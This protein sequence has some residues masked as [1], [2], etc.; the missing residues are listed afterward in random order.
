MTTL[1]QTAR[2]LTIVMLICFFGGCR[3]D[4][5]CY[6]HPHKMPVRVN[7]DWK[8]FFPFERPTGMTVML[9]SDDE[10]GTVYT[11]LTNTT[12]HAYLHI[13]AGTYHTLVFN[14]S[15]TEFGSFSFRDMDIHSAAVV[16]S[17]VGSRWYTRGESSTVAMDAEWMAVG[18]EYDCVLEQQEI[19]EHGTI[20]VNKNNTK[21]V[22]EDEIVDEDYILAHVTPRNIIQTVRVYVHIEGIYNLLSARAALS[23]LSEGY[24]LTQGKTLNSEVTYLIEEFSEKRDPDDPTKGYIEGSF[25]CFGLPDDH[26]ANAQENYLFLQCLLVDNKTIKT[27]DIPVGDKIEKVITE[28]TCQENGETLIEEH[29]ELHLHVNPIALPDVEPVD[30]G[31]SGFDAEVEDW[32]EEDVDIPM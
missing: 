13:P 24:L 10:N 8:R 23:G 28:M 9:F 22:S 20:T 14:Q 3:Q 12:T 29:I 2:V 11:E 21:S 26:Q 16:A 5:L 25:T 32:E 17:Q 4:E 27:F 19:I 30:G 18:N 1:C 7:V 6:L 15:I 31:S